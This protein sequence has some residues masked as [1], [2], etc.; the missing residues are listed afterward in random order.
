MPLKRIVFYKGHYFTVE[1]AIRKNGISE[2]Q[3]FLDGLDRSLR[4]KIVRIIK[5]HADFGRIRNKEH[6]RKVEGD[7]WEYKE[8]QR[9]ILMYHCG[10]GHIALTHGF[11]KKGNKTPRNQ[12][13]RANQIMI[14][15]NRIRKGFKNE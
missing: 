13:D 9:R 7:I 10:P 2:S 8:F 3:G 11:E 1:C 15:Y 14:E 5:R 4:A 12:I 6:F